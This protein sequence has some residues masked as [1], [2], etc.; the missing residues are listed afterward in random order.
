MESNHQEPD[1]VSAAMA[2]ADYLDVVD[3]VVSAKITGEDIEGR[4]QGLLRSAHGTPQSH[5]PTAPERQDDDQVR[6][7]GA[8]S[9]RLSRRHRTARRVRRARAAEHLVAYSARLLPGTKRSD[10][11]EEFHAVL[12]ELEE[13]G[14]GRRTQLSFSLGV[15]TFALRMRLTFHVTPSKR[16][17]VEHRVAEYRRVLQ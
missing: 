9:P 12:E 6:L 5:Q 16:A 15:F 17:A 7:S 4:L 10:W 14:A 13:T 8:D 2:L 1:K 11:A 3:R